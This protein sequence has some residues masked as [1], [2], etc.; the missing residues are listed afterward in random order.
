[1]EN[2]FKIANIGQ[3]TYGNVYL[4]KNKTSLNV[5]LFIIKLYAL[6]TVI[7]NKNEKKQSYNIENEVI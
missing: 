6:K 3:G 7:Y 4:V 2:Y 1:M 5:L